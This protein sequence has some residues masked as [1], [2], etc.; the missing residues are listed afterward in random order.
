MARK[1]IWVY[2]D[3]PTTFWGVLEQCSEREF[4]LLQPD[5]ELVEDIAGIAA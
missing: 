2:P 3:L 1:E 4:S 5:R